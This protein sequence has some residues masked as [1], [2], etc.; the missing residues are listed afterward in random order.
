MIYGF[1]SVMSGEAL[2]NPKISTFQSWAFKFKR[3]FQS[4]S[5]IEN[6]CQFAPNETQN[7]LVGTDI[8]RVAW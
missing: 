1:N 5:S 7:G 8:T 2:H 6:N 3:P 4:S